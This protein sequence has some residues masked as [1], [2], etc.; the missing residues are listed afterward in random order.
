MQPERASQPALAET[1]HE[2]I[3]G[4]R[5]APRLR[6]SIPARL[7][8]LEGTSR[9]ILLDLSRTGAQIGLQHPLRV[10]DGAVL[11][12]AGI[13]SFGIVTRADRGQ[14]GGCNGFEFEDALIDDDVL[15]MR[16]Y[17]ASFEQE[18]QVSLRR[19]VEAWVK[20]IG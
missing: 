4:R 12:V 7:I 9:C 1:G 3:V 2:R 6:L 10:G 11:Q 18:E 17:A 20:G 15:A 19:E 13:D 14:F 16:H 5:N 8:T